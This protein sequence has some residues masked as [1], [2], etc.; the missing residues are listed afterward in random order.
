M[1]P[2]FIVRK[3]SVLPSLLAKPARPVPTVLYG[4]GGFKISIKPSFSPAR[5]LLLKDLN[6]MFAVANIRGGGEFGDRWYQQGIKEKKQNAF[7]DFIAAAEYL[8]GKGFTDSEHLVIQG[9]SNGGLLATAC[10]NQRPELFKGIVAQVPITDMLRFHKFTI[11]RFWCSD[12]GTSDKDDGFK[13]LIKYS[14]LHNIKE[15]LY[16]AVLVTTS[17]HEEKVVPLHAYKYI[18]ELQHTASRVKG[19]RPLLIRINDEVQ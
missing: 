10:A 9:G 3:K 6:M 11:G 19:Q 4:Y 5:L 14:P 13:Y 18:A 12:Y 16:P 7:D 2:M 1:I 17:S 15:Q 8:Q